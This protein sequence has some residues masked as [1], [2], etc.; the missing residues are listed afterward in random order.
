[1]KAAIF[2]CSR[3]LFFFI[4]ESSIVHAAIMVKS[5]MVYAANIIESGISYSDRSHCE[6]LLKTVLPP[7]AK[8]FAKSF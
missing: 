4:V 7:E 8:S 2:L 3:T 5:G 1:M 6:V